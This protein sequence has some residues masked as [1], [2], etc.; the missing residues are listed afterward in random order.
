MKL[1]LNDRKLKLTGIAGLMVYTAVILK[2]GGEQMGQKNSFLSSVVGRMLFISGWALMAYSFG[3]P[4]MKPKALLS[5]GGALGI[6][7]AVMAMKMLK[8][9]AKKKPF[10]LLFIAS[11]I[12]VAIAVGM[13]KSMRSKQLG[14]FALA[15]VLIS[16]LFVL[17]KQ[18]MLTIIDGPGI[19]MFLT[20]FISLTIANSIN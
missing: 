18:R 14:M 19:G 9:P 2:N 5:Y 15:N 1:D 10:G 11:W 3:K 12:A 6:V 4:S 7:I 17:P 13:G 16:M 8:S 20:T